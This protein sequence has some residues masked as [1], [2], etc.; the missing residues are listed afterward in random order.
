MTT[1][2]LIQ[3]G[4]MKYGHEYKTHTNWAKKNNDWA[5]IRVQL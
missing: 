1:T 5:L 4:L 2:A 3:M